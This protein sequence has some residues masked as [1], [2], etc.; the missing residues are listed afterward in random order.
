LFNS[1]WNLQLLIKL[2]ADLLVLSPLETNIF[3]RS[4]EGQVAIGVG[5]MAVFGGE[6]RREG[7]GGKL[8]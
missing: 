5:V 8:S 3:I 1:C 7:R 4:C 2:L 6:L